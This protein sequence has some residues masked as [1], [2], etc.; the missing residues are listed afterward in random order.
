MSDIRGLRVAAV[1]GTI[2]VGNGTNGTTDAVYLQSASNTWLVSGRDATSMASGWAPLLISDADFGQSYI[3]DIEKHFSRKV[4]RKMWLHVNS[5]QPT[6]TANMVIVGAA[7]RGSQGA[8][9]GLPIATATAVVPANTIA[10]V[11]SCKGAFVLNS[12]ENKTVDLTEFIAGGSGP[13]QNE[14]DLQTGPTVGQF[15]TTTATRSTLDAS[16]VVPA[17]ICFAG[18]NTSTSFRGTDI[19]NVVIEQ[20]VDYLDYVGG[21]SAISLA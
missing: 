16:G 5:L 11:Q 7:S 18:N 10:N 20:E 17:S 13:R 8:E 3:G 1:I 12:W 9:Q 2:Y 6:T 19:A 14:F 15:W 4:I 21:M